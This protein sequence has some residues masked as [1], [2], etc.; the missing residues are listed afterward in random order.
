MMPVD[1][2]AYEV[3]HAVKSIEYVSVAMRL[4]TINDR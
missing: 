3:G 4:S 2:P 1:R